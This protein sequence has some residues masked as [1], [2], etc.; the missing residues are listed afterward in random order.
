MEE[1]S[2]VGSQK[3]GGRLSNDTLQLIWS[4]QREI[5]T[6]KKLLSDL[7]KTIEQNEYDPHAQALKDAFGRHRDL[8]LGVPSSEN[9]R[10][11]FNVS[12]QLAVAI[13]RAHIAQKEAQLVEA[14]ERARIEL[15]NGGA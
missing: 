3:S 10:R 9:S 12:P 14:N 5:D 6:G 4:A 2:E 7:E 11:L 13:I 8:Q 1:K 15:L